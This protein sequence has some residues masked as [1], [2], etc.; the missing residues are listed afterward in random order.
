[1][2]K[3]T[4]YRELTFQILPFTNDQQQ[5]DTSSGIDPTALNDYKKLNCTFCNFSTSPR[6]PHMKPPLR[7][8]QQLFYGNSRKSY[9]I[10]S[11]TC[12]SQMANKSTPWYKVKIL[13]HISEILHV[14]YTN[15]QF[16]RSTEHIAHSNFNCYWKHLTHL[17]KFISLTRGNS[18][19][20]S[21]E[22]EILCER[23]PIYRRHLKSKIRFVLHYGCWFSMTN[24]FYVIIFLQCT[25]KLFLPMPCSS[26]M[27]PTKSVILDVHSERRAGP[28]HIDGANKMFVFWK[29]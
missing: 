23:F 10:L 20:T 16:N 4:C 9:K 14:L 11:P 18:V 19:K 7:V 26:C 27:H 28:W 13:S 15:F 6:V 2:C 1:M 8:P 25:L 17:S 3:C 29:L 12:F 5:G 22:N 24:R 21:A